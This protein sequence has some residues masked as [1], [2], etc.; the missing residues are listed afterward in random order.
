MHK[1][2]VIFALMRELIITSVVCTNRERGRKEIGENFDN[3]YFG[4]VGQVIER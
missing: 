4:I 2:K 3:D 1:K